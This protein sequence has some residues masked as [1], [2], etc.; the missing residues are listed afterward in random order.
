MCVCI[1]RKGQLGSRRKSCG[2]I[3]TL[4]SSSPVLLMFCW[5]SRGPHRVNWLLPTRSSCCQD[6]QK[7]GLSHMPPEFQFNSISTPSPVPQMSAFCLLC[8]VNR[9][10]LPPS[11][12]MEFAMLYSLQEWTCLSPIF[13]PNGKHADTQLSRRAHESIMAT[14]YVSQLQT[15]NMPFQGTDLVH[16]TLLVFQALRWSREWVCARMRP[17]G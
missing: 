13:L 2:F 10:L 7:L 15:I 14:L 8:T 3:N 16:R 1:S 9:C 11:H 12:L 4:V 6:G 17:E 5:G